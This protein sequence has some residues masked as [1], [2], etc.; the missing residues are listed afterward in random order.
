MAATTEIAPDIYR[1]SIFAEWGNLQFNHFLLKDDE[2]FLGPDIFMR[3]IGPQCRECRYGNVAAPGEAEVGRSDLGR[4]RQAP[5]TEWGHTRNKAVIKSPPSVSRV[6]LL[7]VRPCSS[8]PRVRVSS[9]WVRGETVWM[10]AFAT[11]EDR[12]SFDVP[13]PF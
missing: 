1:I 9:M 11:Q 10:I 12:K 13:L 8:P 5:E 2:P 4:K 3:S 7:P 6:S